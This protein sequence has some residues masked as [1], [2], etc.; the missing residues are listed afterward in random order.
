M[1]KK[2][3]MDI[4]TADQLSRELTRLRYGERFRRTLRETIGSLIVA[5]AVIVLLSNLLLPA[6]RVTGSGM[7]P[8]LKRGQ[9]VL[10]RK[11]AE[12]ERGDVIAFYYNKK[13]LIKRVIGVAGDTIEIEEDGTVKRN[14]ERLEEPY[15]ADKSY[16]ECDI[17][18]PYEVPDSR[19]FVM[20]DNRSVSVDS[21]STALGCVAEEDI[22][23][24]ISYIVYPIGEAG[25]LES[26]GKRG[27]EEKE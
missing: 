20:G 7:E 16:G 19:Y 4:P 17:E 23:G 14:G 22:L 5:L 3:R 13:I 10:C 21:R 18:F 12:P 15:T 24:R 6:L 27:Y 1:D 9:T 2:E 8:T 11:G 26:G 25:E